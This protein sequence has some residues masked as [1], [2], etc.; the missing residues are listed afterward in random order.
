MKNFF[1]VILFFLVFAKNA[2]AQEILSVDNARSYV[3]DLDEGGKKYPL[4]DFLKPEK[5][6]FLEGHKLEAH[7]IINRVITTNPPDTYVF[8]MRTDLWNAEWQYKIFGETKV[9]KA[10]KITIWN[11]P[12]DHSSFSFD[13]V[14]SGEVPKPAVK[15]VEPH[16]ESYMGEGPGFKNTKLAIFTIYNGE[17]N[18]INKVQEVGEYAFLSTNSD[19]K[20]YLE[21]INKNLDTSGLQKDYIGAL[22]EHKEYILKLSKNGHIGLALDLSKSFAGVVKDITGLSAPKNRNMLPI[23]VV[24]MALLAIGIGF[25]GYIIGQGKKKIESEVLD[26]FCRYLNTLDQNMDKL[27][28]IEPEKQKIEFETIKLQIATSIAGFKDILNQL[29]Q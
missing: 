17:V 6:S 2:Y 1:L 26:Q 4:E 24:A 13:I 28:N 20:M 19:I 15:V 5:L 29:N 12:Q 11:N 7:I 18:P 21:Q 16:F 22:E 3:I 9:Y 23:I 27:K 8:E 14:L 10:V 25:V